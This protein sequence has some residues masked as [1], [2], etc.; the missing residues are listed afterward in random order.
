MY[1]YYNNM[2]TATGSRSASPTDPE[3]PTGAL[4]TW[5]H[6]VELDEIP[7]AIV[8]RAK[9]LSLDGVGCALIGA[10]L[11]WSRVATDAVLDFDGTGDTM[12][13]GTGR[14]A[15]APAAAVL[16]ST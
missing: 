2:S 13:I 4:A 3:G 9:H 6:D 12:V 1:C 7:P 14:T 5:V 10:Q 11:P 8:E 16:N 15:S